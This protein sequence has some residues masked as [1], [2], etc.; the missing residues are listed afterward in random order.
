MSVEIRGAEAQPHPEFEEAGADDSNRRSG[1]PSNRRSERKHGGRVRGRAHDLEKV[2]EGSD[3]A[4]HFPR[5][6]WE[7]D[8]ENTFM[9]LYSLRPANLKD[10][11]LRAKAKVIT[12]HCSHRVPERSHRTVMLLM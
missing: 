9:K 7:R 2:Q 4:R 1:E 10:A 12:K 11:T 6:V 3:S 5:Q 8:F